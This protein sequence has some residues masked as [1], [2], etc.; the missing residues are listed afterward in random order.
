M[1]KPVI[2]NE[3]RSISPIAF[4]ARLATSGTHTKLSTG[5]APRGAG[6]RGTTTCKQPWTVWQ[7][8]GA[9]PFAPRD[10]YSMKI[11]QSIVQPVLSG[12]VGFGTIGCKKTAA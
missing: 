1:K 3:F 7:T 5:F 8:F 2:L 11:A 12:S 4:I 6:G 9:V 10:P